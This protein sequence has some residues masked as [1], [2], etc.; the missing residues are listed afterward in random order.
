M[1]TAPQ[2]G[3]SSGIQPSPWARR[4]SIPARKILVHG[5][6]SRGMSEAMATL[7]SVAAL[8]CSTTWGLLERRFSSVPRLRRPFQASPTS[9]RVRA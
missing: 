1:A 8:G 5:S 4:L 7:L 9:R 3:T 2:S 6:A